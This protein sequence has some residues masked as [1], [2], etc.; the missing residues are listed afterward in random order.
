MTCFIAQCGWLLPSFNIWLLSSLYSV[1]RFGLWDSVGKGIT[2]V[3][4]AINEPDPFEFHYSTIFKKKF[5]IIVKPV[6]HVWSLSLL[7]LFRDSSPL[8]SCLWFKLVKPV[9][10]I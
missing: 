7:F 1:V 3:L 2:E 10:P 9:D 8:R 6:A 5:W 4:Y